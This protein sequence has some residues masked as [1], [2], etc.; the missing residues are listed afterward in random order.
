M[1]D[2]PK[3]IPLYLGLY[4][5]LKE[6]ILVK[7]I[8]PGSKIPSIEE[9]HTMYSVSQ[10]TVSKALELLE[11]EGLI[12][13]KTGAGTFVPDDVDLVMVEP[14]SSFREIRDARKIHPI[15]VVSDG[16]IDAPCRIRHIFSDEE[17]ALKKGQ[18]Y[19]AR[20]LQTNENDPRRRSFIDAFIPAWV[21]KKVTPTQLKKKWIHRSLM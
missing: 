3:H 10:G 6:D 5:K 20:L 18:I 11:R 13:K 19:N 21:M 7:E 14:I 4:W 1:N 8:P 2:S 15:E 16:W 9:L 12:Y 17:G